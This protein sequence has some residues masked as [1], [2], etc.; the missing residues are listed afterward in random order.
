MTTL[1]PTRADCLE[2]WEPQPPVTLA[3]CPVMHRHSSHYIK[4]LYHR[5]GGQTLDS[6]RQESGSSPGDF[7]SDGRFVVWAVSMKQLYTNSFI[8]PLLIIIS[9]LLGASSL[10]QHLVGSSYYS[11]CKRVMG[12]VDGTHSLPF[13]LVLLVLIKL[14]KL[15]Q[16]CRLLWKKLVGVTMTEFR[17]YCPDLPWKNLEKLRN[18]S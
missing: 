8:A 3:V 18:I 4:W 13:H 11:K 2:I 10:I 1:P 17:G 9:P 5:S 7:I 6:H 16:Q 15:V 12:T 14:R